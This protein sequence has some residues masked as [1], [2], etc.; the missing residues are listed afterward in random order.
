MDNLR[1]YDLLAPLYDLIDFAEYEFKRRL[2]PRL[3]AGLDGRILDAG[4]GTGRNIPFYP[5][6]AEMTGIDVSP[7]M[8]A[9]ARARAD[10]LGRHVALAAMDVTRTAFADD[11]FDAV[12]SSFM[13]CVLDDD[14]QTPALA[15]LGRVCRPGGE[16]RILDYTVSERP[17]GRAYTAL[18]RLWTGPIYNAA[19]DRRTER[20]AAPAGL[21][22]LR[23]EPLVQD[24]VRLLVLAPPAASGA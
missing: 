21:T 15:E 22:V 8:L 18:T 7:G 1:R 12:T 16:I 2:R 3:F 11:T 10:R 24:M 14:L 6:D 9:R 13:F 5:A 19:F 20:H 17:L 4:V 23:Q